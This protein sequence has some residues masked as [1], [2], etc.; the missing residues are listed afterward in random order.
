M[1]NIEY[2]FNLLDEKLIE[3]IA[4]LGYTRPTLI[5]RR[6]I[7][8]ILSGVN[9]LLISPTGTGKTEAA[10]FPIY[11][12]ILML[13]N[14]GVK[15]GVKALYI[16]P[17][18]ALNRDILNRMKYIASSIDISIT[19]RHGDTPR[20]ERQKMTEKP[21]DIL[22]TTPE[23]LQFILVNRRFRP[24]LRF[25]RWVI[26]DE[27]HELLDDKRGAQLSVAL[28]RLQYI[29]KY[30]IQR[31][32]LSATIASINEA[33]SYLTGGRL[34]EVITSD[35]EK[36]VTISVVLPKPTSEDE[37]LA[38]ELQVNVEYASRLR[39]I[40]DL[41]KNVKASLIFTNTRDTAEALA[42]K[43]SYLAG[44]KIRVHHGSLAKTERVEVERAIKNGLI[45]AIVAT[46]SLELGIDIG[47][48]DLVI[49]YASPRQAIKLLQRVGRSG[50]SELRTSKGIII[51]LNN[52]DDILESVVLARRAEKGEL[53]YSKIPEKPYDVLAH[54][55]IGI[56]LEHRKPMNA[57]T[58]L[59]ML[60]KA[61]PYRNLTYEELQMVIEQL[62]SQGLIKI[63]DD[64]IKL[65]YGS[66]K[67]YFET[68]M[69]PDVKQ[70]RVFDSLIQRVVGYLDEDF[71]LSSCEEGNAL[72]LSGRVWKILSIDHENLRINVEPA[73]STT[74]LL[75]SWT[76][77]YIPVEYKVARE[78]GAV[79]RLLERVVKGDESALRIL[80]E[81]YKFDEN[82]WQKVIQVINEHS[83]KGYPL[84]TDKSIVVE[85]AGKL[86]IIH[87]HL[88]TRGNR[89]LSLLFKQLLT[90]MM[91]ISLT[92]KSDAYHIVIL[93]AR[94]IS[95]DA[96]KSL[97]DR[98]LSMEDHDVEKVITDSLK[99]TGMY[100]WRLIN[101]AKRFGVIS[102]DASLKDAKGLVRV[103]NDTVIGYE[104][105]KEV[106]TYDID[107]NAILHFVKLIK[108][109]KI[110]VYFIESSEETLSPLSREVFNSL[111]FMAFIQV[112]LNVPSV[113]EMVK[114]RLNNTRVKLVCLMCGKWSTVKKVGE[115]PDRIVCPKCKS[116]F[117]AVTKNVEL[118]LEK[119]VKKKRQRRRLTE[120]EKVIFEE[121][122]RSADL[123]LTYGKVA[124]L[125]L[126]AKG[127]GPRTAAKIISKL[128]LGEMEFYK[129]IVE[130]EKTYLRTR[131]FWD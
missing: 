125:A 83:T 79:K 122:R 25:V 24:H 71:V 32:G 57:K 67:Y 69:I 20:S 64:K 88:G 126:A 124:A 4:S 31:I 61:Y 45:K 128:S 96:L 21:P 11:S 77:E 91:N 121:A 14:G 117:V 86:I 99:A 109:G 62:S 75:P 27:L 101:V 3:V 87:A 130:A 53:E 68:S 118:N 16:T 50:H 48:V 131:M 1:K 49:Q 106:K 22:I 105:I 74:G 9:T 23:T 10:L 102:K 30:N 82:S 28:E 123:V 59:T 60:S 81:N 112:V 56:L 119:I 113:L 120:D 18:R 103:L 129:A 89:G 97:F 13:K 107:L 33:K 47:N 2:P 36:E 55:I 95:M 70:Y 5:Q 17:L 110:K 15:A 41:I 44:D 38:E 73:E 78:V 114:R 66:I 111:Q 58:I 34:C 90:E 92:V 80:K 65:G 35:Y 116:G 104:A 8:V 127:V 72:I 46:S 39:C 115:L 52:V 94:P 76:G 7:P 98:L 85:K 37:I 43:L 19:V 29:S 84:P 54:Q 51:T 40:I 6:A 26:V 108:E 100:L 93:S 63:R 42:S 12:K